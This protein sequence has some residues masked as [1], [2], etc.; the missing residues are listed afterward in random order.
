VPLASGLLAG[1][2]KPDTRF[3]E[4]D[5]RQFNRHGE[6]FDVGETFSGVPYDVGLA[7]PR[8]SCRKNPSPVSR[9]RLRRETPV[10]SHVLIP[11]RSGTW[12]DS[13]GIISYETLARARSPSEGALA[14]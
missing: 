1:K 4:T 12:V 7:A 6:A 11:C 8:R 14:V 13:A 10:D 9:Q 3:E 2:F 5:H